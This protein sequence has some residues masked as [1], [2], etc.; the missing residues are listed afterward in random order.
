MKFTVAT[1][2]DGV[3]STSVEMDI[4]DICIGLDE[5]AQAIRSMEIGESME[6]PD[7]DGEPQFVKRI[8]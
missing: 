3:Y 4:D 2:V 6:V 8:A 1:L 5:W 7:P